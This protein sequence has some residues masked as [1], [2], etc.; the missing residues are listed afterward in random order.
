MKIDY[1]LL[2]SYF[3]LS[4]V[5]GYVIN[6]VFGVLLFVGVILLLNVINF[7]VVEFA[8]VSKLFRKYISR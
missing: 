8:G 1:A 2:A 7:V 5:M 3:V 4:A 6:G